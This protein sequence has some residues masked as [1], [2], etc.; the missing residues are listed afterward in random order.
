MS[1]KH[2]EDGRWRVFYRDESGHPRVKN[3]GRGDEAQAG[4][5]AYNEH[6]KTDRQ[7][8]KIRPAARSRMRFAELAQLYV[9][10]RK[11]NGASEMFVYT[12]RR[13]L[14]EHWLKA[15][16]L[17]LNLIADEIAYQDVLKIAEY[18]R[19]QGRSQATVNRYFGYLRAIFRFGI[20][21]DLIKNNPLKNWQ[22]KRELPRR[23]PL[24]VDDL[25]KI[26]RHADPHLRWAL[27]VQFRLGTRPGP[28]ELLALRWEH[29]NFDAGSISVLATKTKTWREIPISQEFRTRLLEKKTMAEQEARD[30]AEKKAK[31]EGKAKK[32]RQ[33]EI[34]EAV[35]K[36]V[37]GA[38][39]SEYIIEFQGRP[40]KCLRSSFKAALQRAGIAYPC[41]LYD[42]RHL[43][44]TVMLSK[45]AD[46]AAVSRLMGHSSIQQT[47]G[48]YYELLKG[49]KERAIATLP[50]LLEG[51]PEPDKVLPFKAKTKR[52]VT[53]IVTG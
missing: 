12:L 40:V 21:H 32:M 33:E 14:N 7:K 53:G 25:K 27:E 47:A 22:K 45:G 52:A 30:R 9:D 23:S 16:K 11:A 43:F 36:A 1:V 44:A 38:K 50:S 24:T 3:F 2:E 4:A 41:R 10:D 17:N 15:E 20:K 49:E 13:L 48:T 34:E 29:V 26:M 6:L 39:S 5:E 18:Y 28:S 46:L 8:L 35:T 51:G 31:A 37:T 19:A 42:I